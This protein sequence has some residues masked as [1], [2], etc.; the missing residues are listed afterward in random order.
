SDKTIRNLLSGDQEITVKIDRAICSA[1]S[2]PAGYLLFDDKAVERHRIDRSD[3]VVYDALTRYHVAAEAV[4]KGARRLAGIPELDRMVYDVPV[5]SLI[6]AG[7]IELWD[8]PEVMDPMRLPF[9][10]CKGC[11]GVRVVGDSMEPL[12]F[13]GDILVIK[14]RS[15]SVPRQG[16]VYVV[17][18]ED[19]DGRR[20]RAVKYV[21]K[22]GDRWRLA[23]KNLKHAPFYVTHLRKIFRIVKYISNFR[24]DLA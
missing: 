18:W 2:M 16:K 19:E 5:V 7:N 12:F 1:F 10:E 14:D 13:E 11:V 3:P 8:Q 20:D 9:K 4:A 6:P 24:A 15:E 22:E 23:S 17:E 21:F